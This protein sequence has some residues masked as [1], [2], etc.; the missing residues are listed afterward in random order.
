M[1]LAI[2]G[3]LKV[4]TKKFP[5]YNTIGEEEKKAV[6]DVMDSGVLSKF[7]GCWDPDFFGGPKIQELEEKWASYFNTKHAISV[8]SNSSGI[9]CSL[10]ALGIGPGDEVVVSPYTMSVSASSVLVM[11]AVPIFAD[12]DPETFCLDPVSV[13][14]KIT[15]RTKA[16]IAVDIFGQPF[17]DQSLKG[18]AQKHNLRIIEDCAQAPLAKSGTNFAGKLGDLGVFSL[19]YH[20]HIH[21]GEGGIIVTDDDDLAMRC[22]LIRNHGEAV[23]DAMGYK[24]NPHGL[25]GFNLRMTEIE[26]A[27][28]VCQLQKLEGLIKQRQ[29]NVAYLE[30]SLKKIPFLK[31]PE[32]KS[33]ISHSYY[34]HAIKF[35]STIAQVERNTFIEAVK[36]ELDVCEG[37]ESDGVLLSC[38]YVRPL[39]MQSLYQKKHGIG[40]SNFPFGADFGIE[41]PDYTKISLPVVERMHFKEL[42]THELMRPGMTRQDLDDVIKAF[43]KV[44]ENINELK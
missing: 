15:S 30:N 2:N 29:E 27:I 18:I 17:D 34:V 31:I 43:E 39:Y 11:G 26:A 32:I 20:K 5:G 6:M 36:A 24:G 3:G 16:I 8:N 33:G 12:I 1:K 41:F 40:Q 21:S 25:I 7:L 42:F 9:L 44:T 35:N 23:K 4:R 22:R 10:Y 37:R 38:G 19:N 13:E 14:T 28:A